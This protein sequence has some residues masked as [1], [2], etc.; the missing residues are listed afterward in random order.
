MKQ[1][2]MMYLKINMIDQYDTNNVLKLIALTN[3][4]NVFKIDDKLLMFILGV[5]YFLYNIDYSFIK[6]VFSYS[7]VYSLF[8]KRHTVCLTGTQTTCSSKYESY[9]TITGCYSDEFIAMIQYIL[10]HST[11]IRSLKYLFVN[12]IQRKSYYDN[13]FTNDGIYVIDQKEHFCIDSSKKI[14]GYTELFDDE[15]E[16][17]SKFK[18][19]SISIYI[20]SFLLTTNE[21]KQYITDRTKEYIDDIEKKK[22]NKQ[23]E[24]KLI[25]NNID[26]EDK[27]SNW[28]ESVFHSV[29][30]FDNFFFPEKQRLINKVDF[31]L[32]NQSWYEKHGIPYTLGFLL[33]GAPGT[34]KTT[35]IKAL[36]NYSKRHIITISFKHIKTTAD[37]EQIYFESR[38]DRNN[39]PGSIG[40][41]EKIYVLED[42]DCADEIILKR[43]DKVSKNDNQEDKDLAKLINDKNNDNAIL[44]KALIKE[45]PVT[46]DDILNLLDGIQESTGRILVMTTNH[47]EKLDPALIRPGRIDE[48]IEFKDVIPK[49]VE[50]MVYHFTSCKLKL[51]KKKKI[52]KTPADITNFILKSCDVYNNAFNKNLFLDLLYK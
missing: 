42:I 30:R 22:I 41:S 50:E 39:K 24:Y 6:H 44:Q 51:A 17:K 14:Y 5:L 25:K 11:N 19:I 23:F 26:P 8:Y 7:F 37:L 49:T 40:F 2:K 52:N 36:A 43:Q 4:N 28:R 45:S 21:L 15:R 13:E 32:H 27:Y 38:Y 20:Y 47:V 16:E 33:H 10:K 35:F 34:G 18:I 29:K 1:F 9:A 46:L 48:N 3:L 12:I 31:F